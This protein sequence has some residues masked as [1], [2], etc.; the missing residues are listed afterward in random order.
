MKLKDLQVNNRFC[1]S[2]RLDP[3]LSRWGKVLA[4]GVGSVRVKWERHLVNNEH[5][6]LVEEKPYMTAIS[7]NTEVLKAP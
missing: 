1:L 3:E 4:I 6:E 5:G 7:G 2:N